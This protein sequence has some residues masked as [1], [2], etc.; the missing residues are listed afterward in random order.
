M[1]MAGTVHPSSPQRS[2]VSPSC[3][4]AHTPLGR[5]GLAS[6]GLSPVQLAETFNEDLIAPALALLPRFAGPLARVKI[7]LELFDVGPDIFGLLG[8]GGLRSRKTIDDGF[9]S[10]C[11]TKKG[12][13][14]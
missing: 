4:L 12:G 7:F 10:C 14:K 2:R 9:D 5:G 13:D 3:R 6:D 11:P 8:G 1:R